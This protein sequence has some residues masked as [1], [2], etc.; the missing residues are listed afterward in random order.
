[1]IEEHIIDA[2][3]LNSEDKELDLTLRPKTLSDYVGQTKAKES[4]E[5]FIQ[6]AKERKESLEHILIYGPPGLGK[7]T[8]ANVITN[9]AAAH[10]RTTS[11]PAIE[12]A[13]DLASI[14]TNLSDGDVLFIDEIHRLNRVVEEILYPA[15]EEYALDLVI[16]K[17]PSAKTIR[18]DLPHFTLIGATTRIGLIS[19][20]LRDRFG[21]V[22]HLDFY[23]QKEI[24][25]I[26]KRSAKILKIKIDEAAISEIAGRSRGTPRVANRLLK[27]I[28]DYAQVKKI[29]LITKKIAQEALDMLEID[30]K[31]LDRTDRQLLTVIIEKFKGG[32]VGLNTLAAA[33]S[34]EQDTIQDVYEQFLIQTGFLERTN[35]G[36]KV[37]DLAYEHL[38]IICPSG[39]K[40]L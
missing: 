36:R 33:I 8:L 11:G 28:R 7:T 4:I 9:E 18:L 22:H 10:I 14:L 32:P 5:V 30:Q 29:N 3:K 2:K 24:S 35:K 21:L 39:R 1:M 31:G 25:Q 17:G 13:G 26:I 38:G 40:L 34:E 27:R 12:R 20:P 15:M 19:S 37:T 16:G 6:A 23:S